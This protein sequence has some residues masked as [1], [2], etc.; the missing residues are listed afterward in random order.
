MCY[1]IKCHN[2]VGGEGLAVFA[3]LPERSVAQVAKLTA[4]QQ[5]FVDEYLIDLNATQAA[6]RAGYSVQTANEIGAQNL[7]KISIR[8]VIDKALAIRSRRTGVSADRVILE[9]AKIGFANITDVADFDEATVRDDATRDDTAA[10]QS[11]KVKRIPATGGDI[12]EREIKLYNKLDALEKLMR[13]L[14]LG[15]S[16]DQRVVVIDDV[17]EGMVQR[18]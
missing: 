15:A 11:I 8:A 14:G 6:I 16:G 4:K 3:I 18:G 5:R 2:T 17:P 1:D 13:H 12:V 10:I 9:L 7:A